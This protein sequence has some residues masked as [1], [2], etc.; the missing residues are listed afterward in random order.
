MD[1]HLHDEERE[2]LVLLVHL[3]RGHWVTVVVVGVHHLEDKSDREI[4]AHMLP[5]HKVKGIA[6]EKETFMDSL[7][8][9][10]N[11]TA[12]TGFLFQEH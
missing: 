1:G 10:R 4:N 3:P 9:R 12:V 5:Y 7:P 11:H 8:C 2:E 6:Q